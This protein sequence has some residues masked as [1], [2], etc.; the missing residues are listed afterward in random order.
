MSAHEPDETSPRVTPGAT[1]QPNE[2]VTPE[3]A[4]PASDE[5]GAAQRPDFLADLD[6]PVRR[7]VRPQ[8]RPGTAPDIDFR[9]VRQGTLPGNKYIRVL[10]AQ[11]QVFKQVK[12]DYLV[13]GEQLS[14]PRSTFGKL[15][16][17]LVG[18]PIATEHQ[19]HE[20]LNNIKALAVFSSDALSSV[21]YATEAILAVLILAGAAAFGYT[22]P[23]SIAIAILLAIVGISY[24]QTIAAYPNGASAYLVAKANL[25][26]LPSLTAGAS[27]LIDY[28][29]TVAVSVSAGVAA[30]IS[31]APSLHEWRVEICVGFVGLIILGNLRGLRESGTI[32]AVPTYLFVF[33][34]LTL[35]LLGVYRTLTGGDVAVNA[36]RE[37]VTAVES[38][39]VWLILRAFTAGCTALT[40]VEA[41]SDGVPAFKRPEAKNAAKTLTWMCF[42]L[43]FMFIGLSFLA[44]RYGIVPDPTGKE[45]VVS[46]ITSTLVGRNFF[47]YFVQAM[48][49]L[50]LVLAANTSFADFPRLSTWLA[51]DHFMPK[52]FLFRGD[53]LAFNTGITVLG[54]LATA[55]IIVFGGETER[56][57]PLYAVGVFTAFTLSQSGMVIHWFKERGRGW[58]RRFLLNL[59]GATATCFVLVL[60]ILTKF[61]YGAWIVL[62]LMPLLI[63]GFRA[64]HRHYERAAAELA[65]ADDDVP[66]SLQQVEQIV[67]VPIADMNKSTVNALNYARTI[68]TRIV[69]IHVTDDA[70][71]AAHLQ[72]KW[73]KWG[74]GVNLVIL[75]SPYRSLMSPLLSYIDVV[76]KKRPRA[77]VTVLVPEYIPAHWWEQA[78]H[79]QTA[80]RLK[81]ALL[82]RPNTIVT[83]VPYHGRN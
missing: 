73:E 78:L 20:R 65:L 74:E 56:L 7:V 23:I 80:L 28:T 60:V 42:I 72:E 16:R 2:P 70:E 63:L 15:R 24:R 62:M 45:T 34:I 1:Q 30:I 79:S 26:T 12:P 33:S 76:Q 54:V 14:K 36:P 59:V 83:S 18:R 39:S 71:E 51:K 43:G 55:L 5:N 61:I 25:G 77:L 37:T 75:E 81:A 68:S 17:V 29:L 35:I 6:N 27:L 40:G 4:A 11:D 13:A 22:I 66:I 21:A 44:H 47:Y 57:L 46:Q 52:Q 32:F 48:T 10:R 69:G 49:A 50:I 8:R 9:E 31:A 82:L 19:A 67:I 3:T 38:A 53:R 64:I 41:I 58:T